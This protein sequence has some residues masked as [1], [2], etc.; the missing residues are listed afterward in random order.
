MSRRRRSAVVVRGW[1]RT[2]A[3]NAGRKREPAPRHDEEQSEMNTPLKSTALAAA[4]SALPPAAAPAH[5]DEYG[6][7]ISAPQG[8]GSYPVARQQCAEGQRVVPPQPSGGG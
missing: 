5:A 3:K 1:N 4:A 7:V 2:L 8:P 6:N